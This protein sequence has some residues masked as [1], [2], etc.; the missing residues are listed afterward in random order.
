MAA[1]NGEKGQYTAGGSMFVTPGTGTYKLYDF[2]I[3]G[4]SPSSKAMAKAQYIQFFQPKSCRV[5]DSRAYYN[6]GGKWYQKFTTDTVTADAEAADF[7]IPA[8]TGF[9]CNFTKS[10]SVLNYSGEVLQSASGFGI[11]PPT[12]AQ[13]F[14]AY[15]PYP[16]A[17]KLSDLSISGYSPTSKAM[18]KAQY[19]QFM[20]LKSFKVDD[21][22]AYYNYG[23]K[24][25]YKFTSGDVVAD[26]EATDF[27][28]QPGE[29]FLCN[30][31]KSASTV[32]FPAFEVK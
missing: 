9:L 4:Y 24:W 30:F 23:G 20:Q 6:Y 31:T 16:I 5:D 10:G 8:G 19:I 13:Y 32:N 14:F 2:S 17:V 1:A 22:R 15:N 11:Q 29:G 21:S 12:G 27:E 3:T 26:A 25:F 18:A 7:E 28:I